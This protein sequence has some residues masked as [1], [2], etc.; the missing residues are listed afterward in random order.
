MKILI[1]DDSKAIMAIVRKSLEKEGFIEDAFQ[2]ASNGAD[3][4]QIALEWQPD[5]ILTDWHMPGMSG[6]ELMQAI[7]QQASTQPIIGMITTERSEDRLREARSSGATFIM[8]KPFEYHELGQVI[9]QTVCDK[10]NKTPVDPALSRMD[11]QPRARIEND[12]IQQVNPNAQLVLNTDMIID[13]L[14][15]PFQIIFLGFE[16]LSNI[17]AVI[18]L[19]APAIRL[20]AGSSEEITDQLLQQSVNRILASRH[21]I[22]DGELIDALK[23]LRNTRIDRPNG[24]FIE[25]LSNPA[26]RHSMTIRQPSR[27]D[28]RMVVIMR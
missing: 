12:F 24:K 16:G 11:I 6:L 2:Y 20:F 22:F 3:A 25:L 21:A 26:G 15:R 8:H 23:V 10:L 27:E 7:R 5:L 28:G 17:R 18:V 19:D 9:R 4:L 14:V 13:D 1:V